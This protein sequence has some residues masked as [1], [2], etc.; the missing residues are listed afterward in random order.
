MS[1]D[2][3]VYTVIHVGSRWK[4]QNRRQI[5]M[6]DNTQKKQTKHSPENANNAEYSTNG[7][8]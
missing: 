1:T 8:D 2:R 4:I 6:T 7:A 3:L 5:K